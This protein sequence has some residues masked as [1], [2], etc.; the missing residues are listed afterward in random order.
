MVTTQNTDPRSFDQL[1]SASYKKV[2]NLAYRLSGSRSDAEDL[3]QEAFYRAYRGFDAYQGDRPFENWI[4]RIVTRLFLDMKRR[5]SR[6][7]QVMSYDAPLRPD[8]ADD[9]VQF[10]TAGNGPT[11]ESVLLE[12]HVSEDLE[13]SLSRLSE[14]QRKLVFMADVE[15]IPYT[16]IAAQLKT[17]VGTIRSRLHR[18]HKQLRAYLAELRNGG[19]TGLCAGC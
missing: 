3:T 1:M 11:P 18:A 17:P 5:Q 8:G 14:E 6:R 10:D 15:Q 19:Q 9:V 13:K 16:E 4:F 2:F 12:G 7:V